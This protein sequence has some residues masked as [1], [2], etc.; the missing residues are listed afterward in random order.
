VIRD[1]IDDRIIL[2]D[3]GKFLARRA[4][5]IEEDEAKANE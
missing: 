1:K 2:L 4:A 5:S 3:Q